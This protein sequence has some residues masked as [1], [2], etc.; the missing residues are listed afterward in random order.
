VSD[1]R[2]EQIAILVEKLIK[3]PSNTELRA[4]LNRE[5]YNLFEMTDSEIAKIEKWIE[6]SYSP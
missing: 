6:S 1:D 2:V 4:E 3:D 5:V